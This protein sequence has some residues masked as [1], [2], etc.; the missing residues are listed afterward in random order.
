MKKKLVT[1]PRTDARVLST[2]IAKVITKNLN[3]IAKGYRDEDIQKYIKKMSEEKYST[4]LLKTKYVN[5]S[6]ITDHYAIIPTGQG[7]ENYDALP[8]LQKDVYKVIAKRIFSNIL[9]TS[10]IYKNICY[11]CGRRRTIYSKW[12]SMYKFRISRSIKRRKETR[13]KYNRK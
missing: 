4:N 13:K 3:G 10:R 7:Y 1:Y 12:K 9:S 2:A 11:N 5:D 8:Q 6:K